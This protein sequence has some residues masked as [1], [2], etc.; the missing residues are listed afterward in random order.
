LR[1]AA[2]E[3]LHNPYS[4]V[5]S[6]KVTKLRN[7]KGAIHVASTWEMSNLLQNFRHKAWINMLGT[8]R[9]AIFL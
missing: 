2:Q 6:I 4:S 7:T 1:I 8:K 5:N 9:W 3:L